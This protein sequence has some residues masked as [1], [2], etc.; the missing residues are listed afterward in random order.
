V[1]KWAD[2]H[3]FKDQLYSRGLAA[4]VVKHV[5][6]VWMLPRIISHC[7]TTSSEFIGA[8][9]LQ[10]CRCCKNEAACLIAAVLVDGCSP[11]IC[12]ILMQSMI[13]VRND[14]IMDVSLTT[15]HAAVHRVPTGP[16]KSFKVLKNE[17]RKIR[18]WKVMKLGICPEKLIKNANIWWQRCWRINYK[19]QIQ[20]K[21]YIAP[22]SL[23][24]RDRRTSIVLL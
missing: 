8:T 3:T 19:I 1:C 18:P 9:T 6:S 4:R 5:Y 16:E 23:I 13:T 10:K 17:E 14:Q 12:Y 15:L 21:I 7:Y 22:N 24:K 2:E 20:I 11:Y